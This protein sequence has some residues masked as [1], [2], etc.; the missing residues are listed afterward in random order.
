[1]GGFSLYETVD[2]FGYRHNR[3]SRVGGNPGKRRTPALLDS[4]FRRNDGKWEQSLFLEVP[5]SGL[6]QSFALLGN[7]LLPCSACRFTHVFCVYCLFSLFFHF[8][9][10]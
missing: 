9:Q 10:G 1:M 2:L 4:G 5:M 3:H 7:V 6:L 8:V